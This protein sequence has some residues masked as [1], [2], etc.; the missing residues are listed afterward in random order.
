[1]LFP[2]RDKRDYHV[3]DGTSRPAA[4]F[5][6]ASLVEFYPKSLATTPL[7]ALAIIPA[8]H[9]WLASRKSPPAPHAFGEFVPEEFAIVVGI[10]SSEHGGR[11]ETARV[12]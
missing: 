3:E 2:L 5:G 1:M 12:A 4:D 11:I 7:A 8:E 9:V 6:S 10:E